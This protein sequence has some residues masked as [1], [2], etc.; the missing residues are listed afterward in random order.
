MLR[1]PGALLLFL[2]TKKGSLS[3]WFCL[4]CVQDPFQGP[5]FTGATENVVSSSQ[6]CGTYLG[7]C[8]VHDLDHFPQSLE[9]VFLFFTPIE[10]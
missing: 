8:P 3:S 9:E 10:I 5:K 1:L 7:F 6:V 2:A 4:S